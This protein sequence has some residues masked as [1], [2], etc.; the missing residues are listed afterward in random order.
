MVKDQ[1]TQAHEC[2]VQLV[3][4][5]PGKLGSTDERKELLA[6]FQTYYITQRQ[7]EL[8]YAVNT[9]L[10]DIGI[11]EELKLQTYANMDETGL[12]TEEGKSPL[13][14]SNKLNQN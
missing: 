9:V 5:T 2:P 8:E 13:A 11:E 1:I 12:L 4:F 3:S 6:E 10:Y 7:Q 14:F